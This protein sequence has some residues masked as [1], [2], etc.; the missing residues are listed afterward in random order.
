MASAPPILRHLFEK[1][2]TFYASVG[3]SHPTKIRFLP[4]SYEDGEVG[5]VTAILYISHILSC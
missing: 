5:D 3:R 2:K 4:M 1:V